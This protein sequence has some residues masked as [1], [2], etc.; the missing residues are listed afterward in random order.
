MVRRLHGQRLGIYRQAL[1]YTE[2]MAKH[3]S[4][5]D[6]D[7][8]RAARA[9]LGTE[10]IKETVNRALRQTGGGDRAL[11]KRSLDRLARAKLAAREDAWR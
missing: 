9:K 6:E 7:A 8:L 1:V 10:T 5:I 11:V 4:D 2:R 3:L